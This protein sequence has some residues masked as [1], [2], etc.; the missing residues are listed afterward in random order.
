[1]VHPVVLEGGRCGEPRDSPDLLPE[2]TARGW[3]G[4][5][6]RMYPEDCPGGVSV[7]RQ[8]RMGL[9]DKPVLGFGSSALRQRHRGGFAFQE[10]RC[11][12]QPLLC[13]S[14]TAPV[15]QSGGWWLMRLK[16][17]PSRV[18]LFALRWALAATATAQGLRPARHCTNPGQK[19]LLLQRAGGFSS[20][21]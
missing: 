2:S 14:H 1:M 7:L 11:S 8:R 20:S 18:Y 6:R 19:Q 5:L 12:L 15:L 9:A 10:G 4:P 17:R 16:T 21:C 3:C 13:L